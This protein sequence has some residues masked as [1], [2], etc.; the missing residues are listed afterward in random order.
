MVALVKIKGF[1][2]DSLFAVDS[3]NSS[4]VGLRFSSGFR[5]ST[6]TSSTAQPQHS[7]EQARPNHHLR[8]P[9][10]R[11]VVYIAYQTCST[12][13]AASG[14]SISSPASKI[15][16]SYSLAIST[17]IY[18]LLSEISWIHDEIV[19]LDVELLT[20]SRHDIPHDI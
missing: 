8:A 15:L 2:I 3:P 19:S 10:T 17:G 16:Y 20:E 1:V 4:A 12:P 18:S 6:S 5:V 7:T 11:L 14:G 9:L 13:S